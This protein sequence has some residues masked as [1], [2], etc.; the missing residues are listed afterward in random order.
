[1][2]NE[3][4]KNK[5]AELEKSDDIRDLFLAMKLVSHTFDEDLLSDL[6]K[7]RITIEKEQAQIESYKEEIKSLK[8]H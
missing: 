1:M 7:S 3:E 6:E 8:N 5:I 4:I 2:N